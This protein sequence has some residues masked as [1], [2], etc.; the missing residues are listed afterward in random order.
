MHRKIEALFAP[1]WRDTSVW[2]TPS[3]IELPEAYRTSYAK[4]KRA[5]E[6]YM[7]GESLKSICEAESIDPSTFYRLLRACATI[8]PVAGISGFHAL[9]PYRRQKHYERLKPADEN[10]L[11]GGSGAGGLFQQLVS[12]HE[13][14]GTLLAKQAEKY[15]KLGYTGR[16]PIAKEHS[17]FLNSVYAINGKSGYPFTLRNNG[18]EGYR[19]ALHAEIARQR[20]DSRAPY[21]ESVSRAFRPQ[22]DVFYRQVQIDAHRLD[23][24]IQVRFEG[25]KGRSKTRAIRP[26][27]IAAV[28]VDSRACIG[29][30]FS[31]EREPSRLDL[32]RC[33]SN[34]ME[35]WHRR[36]EFAIDGLDYKP[37]AAMPSGVVEICNGRYPDSISLDNA[38]CGHADHIREVVVRRLHAA[39]H[40]GLP[41]EPRT[42]SE[43]E[44]LF[45]TLTH[46][47][48][49]HLKTG[50]RP[51]MSNQ[52]RK[53]AMQEAE[54]N[55]LTVEQIEEYLDV[56]ICNYNAHPTSAHYGK[57]PL[58]ALREESARVLARR[59][60]SA[61]ASWRN[62]L[63]VDLQVPVRAGD[64]H[65]PHVN[66]AGASYT[67]DL[68]RSSHI[69]LGTDIIISCDLNDL[70]TVR[71]RQLNGTS[72]GVLLARG[73]WA[74]FV[75]DARRRKQLNREIRDGNF[76]W[77]P[78]VD[79]EEQVDS[80][81][82]RRKGPE[83]AQVANNNGLLR[84]QA[85]A[86][87]VSQKAERRAAPRLIADVATPRVLNLDRV[88]GDKLKG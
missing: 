24:F 10:V 11:A 77:D 36:V 33:L 74:H 12:T 21:R 48:V 29:W 52:E 50:V 72:I 80:F 58:Q 2:P 56:I 82:R 20:G 76:C 45:N 1:Q 67:N 71:A 13:Q 81:F 85:G 64:G 19:Q 30:S 51:D 40:L 79:P 42:R 27:L 65:P 84:Q 69:L 47:N 78:A 15:S 9:I 35:P 62:L 7:A 54:E 43:V 26:W 14:L 53:A 83:R 49:Q 17:K 68:L 73:P 32:L 59:D 25:R 28:E 37:G 4:R 55:G 86:S 41:G 31:I 44:Q 61:N 75:H 88:L 22:T 3:D 18:R 8:D 57:S 5:V 60:T 70:R 38:L 63:V 6:H 46:R 87:R 16:I 39:L 66:Y 34:M 23:S